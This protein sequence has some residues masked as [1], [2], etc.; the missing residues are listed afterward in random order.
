MTTI[1]FDGRYL[2]ADT[3]VVDAYGLKTLT[4]KI[5]TTPEY[6]VGVSG[7]VSGLFTVKKL[8][9]VKPCE[10][11]E[12]KEDF[13]AVPLQTFIQT[14]I[15]SDLEI[16]VI[17]VCKKTKRIWTKTGAVYTL[18]KPYPFYSLGSGRDFALAAMRLGKTAIESVLIASEFIEGTNN[19][20][21]YVDT[22]DVHSKVHLME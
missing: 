11:L 19:I 5:F 7:T 10:F 8:S 16:S 20:I 12:D 18:H 1:A 21:N 15:P 17:V 14:G 22:N 3:L 13:E 6:A 9:Y 4:T 2:A